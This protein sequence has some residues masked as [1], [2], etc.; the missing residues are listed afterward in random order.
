MSEYRRP[1]NSG[2]PGSGRPSGSRPSGSRSATGMQ[3]RSDSSTQHRSSGAP[4][5][6]R[7]ASSQGRPAGTRSVSS[8]RSSSE[9]DYRNSG[10]ASARSSSSRSA[11][12]GSASARGRKK[13]FRIRSRFFYLCFLLVYTVILLIVSAIFLGYVN[14]SLKKYEKSQSTFAMEEY[15]NG[16]KESLGRGELPEGFVSESASQFESADVKLNNLLSATNGRTLAYEKDANSY[17]TEEPVYDITADGEKVAE[18]TL[19]AV[20]PQVILGILTIMDWEVKS[21]ELE[22]TGDTQDYIINAPSGYKVTVNGVEVSD[23]YLT[24]NNANLKLFANAS[25]YVT[26]PQMVEYKIPALSA[27]P[28]VT[29]TDEAGT[30]HGCTLSGNTFTAAFGTE[31]E[32]PSDLSAE[33]LNIAETWSL[34][35]TADLGGAKYGLD[36]VRQYLIPDS[37]Y[38][39]L[40]K[41]WAGG[42]DITFTSAHTLQNPAFKNVE[43]GEY[44]RYT[45]D[46]FSC[47]I[48]FDKPMHLTRTGEDIVDSTSSTY[49]FV[50]YN[51]QWC[52]VDMVADTEN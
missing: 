15:F 20:N 47:H 22:K 12:S 2:R 30:E 24:G 6:S 40:A 21:A 27:Q 8:H 29:V 35:M 45:D 26:I 10:N 23:N 3:R 43:I 36:K 46:C 25:D 37:F 32:M 49:L 14:R 7:S 31:S 39:G 18:V 50:K 5:R 48:R 19:T 42:I 1:S 38:D 28:T 34:F 33:A 51:G 17:N 41:G 11:S 9:R 44:I 16:F 13:K 52:L 4:Q